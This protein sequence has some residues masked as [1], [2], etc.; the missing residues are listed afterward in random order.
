MSTHL[1]DQPDSTTT[2]VKSGLLLRTAASADYRGNCHKENKGA[3][4]IQI[5][6]LIQDLF[7]TNLLLESL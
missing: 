2:Q 5:N 3:A 4:N 7:C 6:S 1:A